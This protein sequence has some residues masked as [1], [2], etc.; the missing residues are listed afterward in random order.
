MATK[1]LTASGIKSLPEGK[2]S[3]NYRPGKIAII[4]ID[5]EL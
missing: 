4:D 2:H 3:V 5:Q 1:I